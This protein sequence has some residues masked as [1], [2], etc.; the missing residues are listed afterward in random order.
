[1]KGNMSK[2]K[3]FAVAGILSA[4]AIVVNVS[5]VFVSK[6]ENDEILKAIAGYKTWTKVT[7]LVATAGSTDIGG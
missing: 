6:A 7:K 3:L 2:I 1:M 4:V 5:P